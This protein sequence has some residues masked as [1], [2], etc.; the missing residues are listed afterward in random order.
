MEIAC[1][2][3]DTGNKI[4]ANNGIARSDSSG[5]FTRRPRLCDLMS[6]KGLAYLFPGSESGERFIGRNRGGKAFD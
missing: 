5:E 2:L 4:N 1:P 3:R 6:R